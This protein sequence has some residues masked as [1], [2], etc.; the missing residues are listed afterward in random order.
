MDAAIDLF[1]PLI[2]EYGFPLAITLYLLHRL[3]QKIDRVTMAVERLPEQ[4]EQNRLPARLA[5]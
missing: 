1:V 2:G 3:E 5:K 4:L